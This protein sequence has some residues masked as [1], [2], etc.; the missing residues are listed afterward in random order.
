MPAIAALILA[1][2][3]MLQAM[4][5]AGSSGASSADQKELFNYMLTLDKIH[6]L[7]DSM[8][9]MEALEKSNPELSKSMN[10]DDSEGNLDQLTQKIQKYPPVVAVLKKNGLA[11]REYIVMTMTLIQAGLA[12][13]MKKAGTYQDYPPKMLELV[14]Q[15]NLTFLEKNWDEVQKTVPALSAAGVETE[16]DK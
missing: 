3:V 12:V 15:V 6:K 16:G 4:P 11:P 2:S 13:G 8:K 10:A 1:S 9:D 14:S 7:G 5:Q